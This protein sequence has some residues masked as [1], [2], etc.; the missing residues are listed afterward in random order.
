MK[1]INLNYINTFE[2]YTQFLDDNQENKK[3]EDMPLKSINIYEWIKKIASI[4]NKF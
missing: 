2:R 3:L 4:F 1:S